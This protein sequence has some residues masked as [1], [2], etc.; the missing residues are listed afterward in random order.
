MPTFYTFLKAKPGRYNP[1]IAS[2]A[3][4]FRG[5]RFSSLPTNKQWER[6]VVFGWAGVCGGDDKRAPLKTP[7]WEANPNTD[8]YFFFYAAYAIFFIRTI[9]IR[10]SSLKSLPPS[11]TKKKILRTIHN[12][13]RKYRRNNLF[14]TA[15][16]C[17]NPENLNYTMSYM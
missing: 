15:F 6:N 3:V 5:A 1:N 16:T 12:M 10:T 8:K 4:V 14:F 13:L 9:F 17:L 11:K 7:A 2:Y